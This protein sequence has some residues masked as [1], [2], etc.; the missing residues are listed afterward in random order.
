MTL[1]PD[2]TPTRG[3]SAQTALGSFDQA[4]HP[5]VILYPPFPEY[6]PDADFETARYSCRFA[7]TAG[8]LDTIQRLR[9]EV[10]N[11]ELGEGLAESHLTRRDRDPFDSQCH[12]LM[13]FHRDVDAVVG[14]YRL[15]T[16][17]AAATAGGFYSA[18][19]FD[20]GGL[21]HEVR[22]GAV[23]IG[24]ACISKPHRNSRVLHLLWQGLV[25]YMQHNRKRYLF[26]CSSVTTQDPL[27]AAR[28]LEKLR[29]DGYVH[30]TIVVRPQ[31]WCACVDEATPTDG[32]EDAHIPIL[33]HTYLRHGAKICGTPAI[34]RAFKTI[35][36]LTFIDLEGVDTTNF[37]QDRR[38][39]RPRKE[40]PGSAP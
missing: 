7:R 6:L 22:N 39:A 34:D 2:P 18:T 16:N 26:G 3:A 12:H 29:R 30:P 1:Q 19:E 28:V 5:P 31:S 21:P 15:Q 38:A 23:E 35:D 24:R 36:F 27:E 13:T 9:Y 32:W 40:D 4:T 10:F 14:T 37:E 25:A 33:F 17:E 11:L 8:D 20:L